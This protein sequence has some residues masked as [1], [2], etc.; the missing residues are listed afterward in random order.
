MVEEGNEM[1]I[2]EYLFAGGPLFFVRGPTH[3][4]TFLQG[5]EASRALILAS[6][7]AAAVQKAI[8]SAGL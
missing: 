8:A 2:P 1:I 6:F 3:L 5:N 4:L 7:P